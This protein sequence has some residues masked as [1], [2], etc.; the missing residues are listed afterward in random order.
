MKFVTDSNT[1][2]G[3]KILQTIRWRLC[4]KAARTDPRTCKIEDHI[5]NLVIVSV[6]SFSKRQLTLTFI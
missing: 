4:R 3:A 5:K 1:E 6:Y 2:R